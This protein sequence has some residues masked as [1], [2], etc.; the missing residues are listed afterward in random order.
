MYDGGMT[1]ARLPYDQAMSKKP[2]TYRLATE[3]LDQLA[4]M[5]AKETGYRPDRT[6]VVK[7]LL[8]AAFNVPAARERA[9]RSLREWAA[10]QKV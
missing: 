7:A 9:V 6:R 3:P 10:Q 2:T 4:T 1:V 8:S 5:I